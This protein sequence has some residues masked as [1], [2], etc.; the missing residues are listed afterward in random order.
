MIVAFLLKPLASKNLIV[1]LMD[2]LLKFLLAEGVSKKVTNI[3]WF[4]LFLL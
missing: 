2:V 4:F 1:H 3:F